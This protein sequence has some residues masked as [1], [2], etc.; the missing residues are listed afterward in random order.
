MS[1]SVN[2]EP[3]VIGYSSI[4]G[5]GVCEPTFTVME[6]NG[7]GVNIQTIRIEFCT[8]SYVDDSLALSSRRLEAYG[9]LSS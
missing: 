2:K 5:Y 1:I 3:I 6:N 4:L 8:D 9:I 7:V